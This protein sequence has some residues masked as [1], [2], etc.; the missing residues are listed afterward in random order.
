MIL[1][2]GSSNTAVVASNGGEVK[3]QTRAPREYG[4]P[5]I[6]RVNGFDHGQ[7][8]ARCL[9]YSAG[10]LIVLGDSE[11]HV[12]KHPCRSRR[13]RLEPAGRADRS[14]HRPSPQGSCE[15]ARNRQF[16]LDPAPR[17][18]S[19]RWNGLQAG[20]R[21]ARH[22]GCGGAGRGGAADLSRGGGAGECR[23]AGYRV[24]G[25]QSPGRDRTADHRPRS[26]GDRTQQ[27]L[28][29]GRGDLRGASLRGPHHPGRAAPRPAGP[30]QCQR[31]RRQRPDRA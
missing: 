31:E 10:L 27:P 15:G 3:P 25:R 8:N 4:S 20:S 29:G 2:I 22:A 13:L 16:C 1:N 19:H 14:C 26:R 11:G 30:A 5:N 9:S 12:E 24:G 17:T 6:H 7:I 28:R 21:P 23:L 18:G